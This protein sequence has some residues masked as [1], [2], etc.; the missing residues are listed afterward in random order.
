MMEVTVSC[1]ESCRDEGERR[2]QVGP[3]EMLLLGGDEE[4]M[5]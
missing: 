4:E 2:A 5:K 1:R 3:G